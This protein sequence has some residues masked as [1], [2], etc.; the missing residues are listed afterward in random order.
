M[1]VGAAEALARGDGRELLGLFSLT[2][3]RQLGLLPRLVAAAAG[4]SSHDARW[5]GFT[6]RSADDDANAVGTRFDVHDLHGPYIGSL[7]RRTEPGL[8]LKGL[9]DLRR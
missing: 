9:L 3:L 7:G 5:L 6:C 8:A 1:S 2:L 4:A